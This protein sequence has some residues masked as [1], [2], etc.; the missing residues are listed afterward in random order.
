[1]QKLAV[2][3][4]ERRPFV[5]TV[6]AQ[7]SSPRYEFGLEKMIAL[8]LPEESHEA[9]EQ[10]SYRKTVDFLVN[11]HRRVYPASDPES[12]NDRH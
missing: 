4:K 11:L 6:F 10:P 2:R 5:Y 9:F 3:I 7:I 1:M 8:S 12:D